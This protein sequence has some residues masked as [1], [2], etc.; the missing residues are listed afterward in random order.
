MRDTSKPIAKE[1]ESM[2]CE[3]FAADVGTPEGA[4][5]AFEG[6]DLAFCMTLSEY[7]VWNAWETVRTFQPFRRIVLWLIAILGIKEFNKGKLQID[8]AKAAG[9][10]TLAWAG[11]PNIT[12]LSGGK[13]KSE[14]YAPDLQSFPQPL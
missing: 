7:K 3:A 4:N 1:L 10:K 5:K 12:E 14:L 6:A 2:G 13:F 9:I 8:A 11:A